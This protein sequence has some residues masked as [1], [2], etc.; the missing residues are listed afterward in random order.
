[1]VGYKHSHPGHWADENTVVELSNGDVMLNMR[2]A[3][4]ER[5]RAVAIS[6]DGGK[7][8]AH[9]AIGYNVTTPSQF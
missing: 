8:C 1:M 9:H 7:N 5:N 3:R 6:H 2:N 4:E